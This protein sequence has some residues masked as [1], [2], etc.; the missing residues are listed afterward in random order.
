VTMCGQI[1]SFPMNLQNAVASFP[2]LEK[3]KGLTAQRSET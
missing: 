1:K 2:R 3:S